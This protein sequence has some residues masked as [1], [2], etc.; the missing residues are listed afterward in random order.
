MENQN[1]RRQAAL[2]IAG[3]M[4]GFLIGRISA[5]NEP[6]SDVKQK[7]QPVQTA[8]TQEKGRAIPVIKQKSFDIVTNVSADDDPYIGSPDAPLT[9]VE[10]T[11]FQCSY[12]R[13]YFL[14][15]FSRLKEDYI[16][17]NRVRY[18]V[19]DFPLGEHPQSLPAAEAA[20][21][22]GEQNKYWQM[23]DMLFINQD[24]WSYRD[25][26]EDIFM[27]FAGQIQ[28]DKNAFS[29]CLETGRF[30]QEIAKDVSD[31]ELYKVVSTPTIFIGGKKV[32]GAQSYETF[33]SIIEDEL[34]NLWQ[35]QETQHAA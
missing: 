17:K 24:K 5:S 33:R 2:L 34:K 15:S 6:T 19:R 9:I 31:A 22:A 3:I 18:V 32:I 11:D 29:Y 27:D 23:H 4:A 10:F 8:G 7:L 13:K 35:T 28:L 25:N 21:C 30:R 1:I 16:D 14:G 26:A 12:C 20:E